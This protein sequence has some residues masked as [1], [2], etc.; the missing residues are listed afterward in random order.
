[1]FCVEGSAITSLC[2]PQRLIMGKLG[3]DKARGWVRVASFWLCRMHISSWTKHDVICPLIFKQ[4]TW[5]NWWL[6]GEVGRICN[7]IQNI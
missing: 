5:S 1:M 6:E 3:P 7:I 2:R 4:Y